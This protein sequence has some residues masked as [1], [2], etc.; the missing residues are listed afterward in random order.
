MFWFNPLQDYLNPQPQPVRTR[1]A[2]KQAP[3]EFEINMINSLKERILEINE[4]QSTAIQGEIVQELQLLQEWS[5]GDLQ[6]Y[7]EKEVME[8]IKK[9][10]ISPSSSGHEVYD[11]VPLKLLSQE[12]QAKVIESCWVIGTSLSCAQGSFRLAKASLKSQTRKRSV[13]TH[14]RRWLSRIIL[15]MSQIHKWS[16]AVSDAASAFLTTPVDDSKGFVYVHAPQE[17]QYPDPT[18]WRLKR[19]LCGL[20]DSPR[21]WHWWQVHLTQVLRCL[22]LSQMRSDP[23]APPIRSCQPHWHGICRWPSCFR[24]VILSAEIF[25]EI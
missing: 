3:S 20:W 7:L 21:S 1:V 14:L 9:E 15:M 10:L 8:V 19:Q 18:V 11:P 4:N 6:G 2:G 25:Q 22:N 5:Q 13:L 24:G 23:C 16:L 12:D 17:I